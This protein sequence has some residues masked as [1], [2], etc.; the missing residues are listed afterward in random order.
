MANTQ[1]TVQDVFSRSQT[2][3]NAI[4]RR[5][6]SDH[7][8]HQPRT[9]RLDLIQCSGRRSRTPSPFFVPT[10][11]NHLALNENGRAPTLE[12][13]LDRSA[14]EDDLIPSLITLKTPIR[15]IRPSSGLPKQGLLSD[16]V[17]S[18]EGL[19]ASEGAF[20]SNTSSEFSDIN[21]ELVHALQQ[22]DERQAS[23]PDAGND[24]GADET[25]FVICQQDDDGLS[26]HQPSPRTSPRSG[27]QSRSRR[28]VDGD[29]ASRMSSPERWPTPDV[30]FDD[31]AYADE[32]V[33]GDEMDP[34]GR[35]RG[36]F[37]TDSEEEGEEPVA[38]RPGLWA[39]GFTQT[40]GMMFSS[41]PASKKCSKMAW[42]G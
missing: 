21:Q 36:F 19:H 8:G 10:L 6:I 41:S 9:A 2:V 24:V 4:G 33:A 11:S 7:D 30:H 15:D 37:C 13:S 12:G 38:R 22:A 42:T 26:V 20:T 34:L 39:R 14:M 3:P 1:S 17:S 40:I 28:G 5:R 29:G 25:E 27:V 32:F 18:A 31:G 16:F 35:Y 23:N